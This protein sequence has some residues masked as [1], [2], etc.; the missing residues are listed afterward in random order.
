MSIVSLRILPRSKGFRQSRAAIAAELCVIASLLLTALPAQ[1]D[2]LR[3]DADTLESCMVIAWPR[4]VLTLCTGI[5]TDP[6][7]EAP[8]GQSTQG[9]NQCCV[10]VGRAA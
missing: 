6:C 9:M 1:A 4:D 7:Q 5:V 3:D 10:K 8:G 2:Q